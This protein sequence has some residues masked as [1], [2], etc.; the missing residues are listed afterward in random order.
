MFEARCRHRSERKGSGKFVGMRQRL[1]QRKTSLDLEIISL[2]SVV[3]VVSAD[4][5]CELYEN[6]VGLEFQ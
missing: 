5:Y 2:S 4:V 1:H 6:F 3:K